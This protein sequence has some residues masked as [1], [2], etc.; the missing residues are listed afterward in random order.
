MPLC[1]YSRRR[2]SLAYWIGSCSC[3]GCG[4]RAALSIKSTAT[5][6]IEAMLR[7]NRGEP[8]IGAKDRAATLYPVGPTSGQTMK[9]PSASAARLRGGGPILWTAWRPCDYSGHRHLGSSSTAQIAG[10]ESPGC[11]VFLQRRSGW[12]SEHDTLRHFAGG[13]HAPERDEQFAC[14]GDDHLRLARALDTLGPGSEPLRQHAVPLKHEEA[15]S[16]LDHAAAYPGIA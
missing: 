2:I 3:G 7:T 15:P 16:Q 4:Q 13:D 11:A 10:V 5:W 9:Q 1:H 12:L 14:Q 6:S 8:A